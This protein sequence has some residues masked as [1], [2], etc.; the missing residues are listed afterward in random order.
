MINNKY[1][2][3]NK[4]TFIGL[5]SSVLLCGSVY[6]YKKYFKNSSKKNYYPF[7]LS[8]RLN[9]LK[10]APQRLEVFDKTSLESPQRPGVVLKGPG[11]LLDQDVQS[12][13][14]KED[15]IQEE[16]IVQKEIVKDND[17]QK[18]I[19]QEEIVNIVSSALDQVDEEYTI[20]GNEKNNIVIDE[21]FIMPDVNM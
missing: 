7:L 11:V 12:E 9:N 2:Q 5:L 8:S 4:Y 20:V 10:E 1:L 16:T 19:T 13:T 15:I 18:T 3:A 14:H 21:H 6:L 17:H